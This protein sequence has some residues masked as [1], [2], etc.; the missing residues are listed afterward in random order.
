MTPRDNLCIIWRERIVARVGLLGTLWLD[1]SHPAQTL[2]RGL[3]GAARAYQGLAREH[4]DWWSAN[5]ATEVSRL[6]TLEV[7]QGAD[8]MESSAAY[9]LREGTCDI[10]ETPFSVDDALPD[11]SDTIWSADIAMGSGRPVDASWREVQP[12]VFH[13]VMPDTDSGRPGFI[14]FHLPWQPEN[15]AQDAA[16][17]RQFFADSLRAI[18]CL[19][20]TAGLGLQTP[21]SYRYF[22]SQL[23]AAIAIYPTIDRCIGLEVYDPVECAPYLSEAMYTV[24]WL[25]YVCRDW[26]DKAGGGEK[27]RHALGEPVRMS[28]LVDG[29]TNGFLFQADALPRIGEAGGASDLDG[30]RQLAH[31]L[32]GLRAEKMPNDCIAP[33]PD[34]FADLAV[35]QQACARYLSRFD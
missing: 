28:A 23:D 30:Y 29:A 5:P 3:V 13:A 2:W 15:S 34:G 21:L 22:S 12:W 25:T 32:E 18:P 6:A 27:L 26:I 7:N 33:P 31:A 4:L 14:R 8:E 16:R 1:G 19:H 20:A 9:E 24:N 17:C 10:R 11:A 35:W